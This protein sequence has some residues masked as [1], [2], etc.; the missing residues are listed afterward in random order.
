MKILTARLDEAERRDISCQVKE[1]WKEEEESISS[2]FKFNIY[3][4]G[5]HLSSDSYQRQT[6][7]PTKENWSKIKGKSGG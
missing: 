1:I 5:R 4:K 3:E 7:D 2:S 6:K